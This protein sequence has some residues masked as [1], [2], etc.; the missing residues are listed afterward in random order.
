MCKT[1]VLKNGTKWKTLGRATSDDIASGEMVLIC[2]SC[3][4]AYI[5]KA[6]TVSATRAVSITFHLIHPALE[7]NL[8]SIP[9]TSHRA[10]EPLPLDRQLGVSSQDCNMLLR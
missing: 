8:D 7:R 9:V 1:I 4:V 10:S 2:P 6:R 3:H 5:V